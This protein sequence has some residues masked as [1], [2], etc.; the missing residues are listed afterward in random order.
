MKFNFREYFR[1]QDS[2]GAGVKLLVEGEETFKTV[3]GAACSLIAAILV[4]AFA[5]FD[6]YNM[7]SYGPTAFSTS[8]AR[9][10][11]T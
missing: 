8:I 1:K 11:Y 7:F 10:A 9:L 3:P 5:I 4:G 6:A 2:F